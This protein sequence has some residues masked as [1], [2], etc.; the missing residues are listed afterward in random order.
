MFAW[1]REGGREPE[2]NYRGLTVTLSHPQLLQCLFVFPCLI[3]LS[4][5]ECFLGSLTVSMT[6][7]AMR[8]K[9]SQ[10]LLFSTL[11]RGK[12]RKGNGEDPFPRNEAVLSI[13][14]RGDGDPAACLC[15][16]TMPGRHPDHSETLTATARQGR[17]E[18]LSFVLF[19]RKV[20][21]GCISVRFRCNFSTEILKWAEELQSW[22]Y[23]G[24]LANTLGE[25]K[26]PD[27]T[28][29]SN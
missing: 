25:K 13:S 29:I 14:V 28:R 21:G 4:Q 22:Q 5:G 18:K 11:I 1:G 6:P 16:K 2:M 12:V 8:H 9:R 3:W 17:E 20:S 19:M 10:T 15:M 7:T 27:N 24:S 26:E 23:Q